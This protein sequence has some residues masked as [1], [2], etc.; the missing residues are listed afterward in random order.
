M[1][2]RVGPVNTTEAS[3]SRKGAERTAG[4]YGILR[5]PAVYEA[6]QRIFNAESIRQEFATEFVQAQAGDR[7]LDI[8]CGPGDIR[9]HLPDVDYVGWE[10]NEAYVARARQTYGDRGT[11]HAGFFGSPQAAATA[12]VDVAIVSAVLHHMD[13]NEVRE[14]F[15]LLRSVLKPGGR[16]VTM[17]P[18]FAE[19][20]GAVARLLISLDRGRHVR[21]PAGY[22][23]LAR[24]Q[25]G[26][27]VGVVRHRRFPPYSHFLMAARVPAA[28]QGAPETR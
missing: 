13:D 8:G 24:E 6:V 21:P 22:L 11:F 9:P 1:R 27:V 5:Q 18:V 17:D 19:N 23:A 7:V 14:L 12:P 2:G 20:Q 15:G 16:V 26:S 3:R 28:G 4:L 10:P 25:F